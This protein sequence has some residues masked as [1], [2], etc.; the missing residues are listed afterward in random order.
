MPVNRVR[1]NKDSAANRMK[2]NGLGEVR[3]TFRPCRE[4]DGIG[5]EIV[6]DQFAWRIDRED[7]LHV[8]KAAVLRRRT[9]GGVGNLHRIWRCYPGIGIGCDCGVVSSQETVFVGV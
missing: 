5:L 8:I 4:P 3:D 2:W 9:R 7:L 1:A 6:P